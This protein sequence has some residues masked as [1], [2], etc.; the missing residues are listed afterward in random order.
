M[1]FEKSVMR[2]AHANGLTNCCYTADGRYIKSSFFVIDVRYSCC[3]SHIITSGSDGDI[4]IWNGIHDDDPTSQCVGEFVLAVC[5]YGRR[6]LVSTDLNTVQALT[7]PEGDRDGIE[8]RFTAAITCIRV[9]DKVCG[10]GFVLTKIKCRIPL[11]IFQYI[12]AGS[13]DTVIKVVDV[14]KEHE[15]FE[16][17]GHE[18]PVL[19]VDTHAGNEWLA[20]GGGDGTIRVWDLKTRKELKCIRGL[21]KAKSIYAAKSYRRLI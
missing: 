13:E 18:G 10:F 8:F 7:F 15:P 12:V 1:P 3:Y 17:T 11:N 2:F 16:L 9:D 5:H 14:A 4:R 19:S 6:M 21:E 20:S